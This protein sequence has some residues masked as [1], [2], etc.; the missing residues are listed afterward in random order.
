VGLLPVLAG[1]HDSCFSARE[2]VNEHRT[3]HNEEA[4]TRELRRDARCAW[5][6][7][8][9]QFPRRMFSEEFREGFLDGYTDYLDRGGDASPPLAPPAKLTRNKKYYSP[10]GQ[11]LLKDY[12]LGFKYGTEVAV[13]TGCRQFLT[14]PVLLPTK[15]PCCGPGGAP[16]VGPVVSEPV[17]QPVIVD[18]GAMI[19]PRGAN[20][21]VVP[22]AGTVTVPKAIPQSRASS[23]IQTPLIEPN[24]KFPIPQAPK[25]QLPLS[26][27]LPIPRLPGDAGATMPSL[28]PPPTLESKVPARSGVMPVSYEESKFIPR[29]VPVI[30]PLPEPP[31]EVPVLPE[32]VPTPSVLDDLPTPPR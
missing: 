10:E 27:P 9:C 11:S 22:Q 8:R 14:V 17:V 30:L 13:A 12:L 23:K 4:L 25:E 31:I 3:Y 6:E 15:E 32:G 19:D 21:V 26:G 20:P 29:T 18:P 1:C 24:Q 7:V 5:R 28:P 2:L 16:A